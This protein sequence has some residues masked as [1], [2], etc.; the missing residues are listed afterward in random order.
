M[1]QHELQLLLDHPAV[2]LLR[3]T[4]APL[5]LG[6]LW[7]VFKKDHRVSLPEGQVQALLDIHLDEQRDA[8][9]LVY[10]KSAADYLNDWCAPEHGFLRRYYGP[11]TDEPLYELTSGSEKALLWL[12][13]MRQSKFVGTESR[14]ESVFTGLDEILKYSSDDPTRRIEQL[15]AEADAIHAEID[16]IEATG[17]AEAFTPVQINERYGHVLATAREL[18]SDFRQ[19]EHNFKRIAHE[20][21][22]HHARPGVTK[23]AIVAHLLDSHDALRQSEQGQSFFAFWELLLS[24]DKQRRFHE[25]L[26]QVRALAALDPDHRDNPLLRHF[27]RHLLQE[28]ECVVASHQRLSANLRR[29]LDT[30]HLAERRRVGEL[31]QEIRQAALAVRQD[32]PDAADFFTIPTFPQVFSA[33]GRPL[34][35]APESAVSRGPIEE[36]TGRLTLADMRRFHDLPEIR[37]A[38]LR[39]NVAACLAETSPIML[40]HVLARFPLREGVMELVGYLIVA[41]DDRHHYVSETDDEIVEW[42]PPENPQR[43]RVP[44]L[45]FSRP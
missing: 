17:R 34:W 18:L 25:Q 6:F 36:E 8:D 15:L 10:P 45:L 38:E 43:W 28:G 27:L 30:T 32:P 7:Q 29:V 39:A 22:E 31:L 5:I 3:A 23:G 33:F 42:G 11:D 9:P 26:D 37:L 16:R 2:R 20:I 40:S 14:L 21:A 44:M 19:V 35:Q 1:D 41:A 13:S 24:S 12:E 4:N